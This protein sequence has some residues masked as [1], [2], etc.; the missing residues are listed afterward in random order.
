MMNAFRRPSSLH[1][2]SLRRFS[3]P[4]IQTRSLIRPQLPKPRVTC[5]TAIRMASSDPNA[6]NN[7][8]LQL[9]NLF[10]VK[11]KVALVTGGGK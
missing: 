3:S 1:Q 8:D 5:S 9:E 2:S 10:N 6:S 7:A 4:Q 11:D